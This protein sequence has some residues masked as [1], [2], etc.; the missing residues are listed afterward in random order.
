MRIIFT[1]LLIFCFN[2]YSWAEHSD[3]KQD[4]SE[5]SILLPD[6]EDNDGSVDGHFDTRLWPLGLL[7][8]IEKQWTEE[9]L[10]EQKNANT[11]TDAP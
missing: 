1:I 5:E 6:W 11:S 10:K 3:L 8:E 7:L 9:V 4:T 2:L